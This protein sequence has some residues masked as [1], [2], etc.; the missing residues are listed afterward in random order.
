MEIINSGRKQ[1]L[2]ALLFVAATGL[3]GCADDAGSGFGTTGGTSGG[4]TSGTTGGTTSGTTSGTTGGTTSGTTGGT[5]SG[6]TGGTT[7]GST[8]G[9]DC[10]PTSTTYR[11]IILPNATV[12]KATAQTC[13]VC[14]V[15]NETN[16]IDADLT[17]F[18]TLDTTIG[19]VDGAS[20]TVNDTATTYPAGRR[21]GFVVAD[22]AGALLTLNLLQN[23]T[24]TTV[25]NGVD[26][27]SSVNSTTL[28]VDLLGMS[29]LGTPSAPY[30]LSYISNSQFNAV[31]LSY[32]STVGA[33]STLNAYDVCV[34][35]GAG[36]TPP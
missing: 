13:L 14:A 3:V 24:I 36:T 12:A 25:L 9:I 31:R 27:D 21:V 34:S 23:A 4:T 11:P 32:G 10:T 19:L 29:V 33:L 35:T 17:N 22:P 20:V 30:F 28:S 5:T 7:G 1:A 18:A 16:V 8:G 15:T 6:T 26:Q 2:A